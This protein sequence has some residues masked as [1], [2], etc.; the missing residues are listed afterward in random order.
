MAT[1]RQKALKMQKVL[2]QQE[3]DKIL[4]DPQRVK[5]ALI[6]A[7]KSMASKRYSKI[8]RKL[9]T[10]IIWGT[11]GHQDARAKQYDLVGLK[12]LWIK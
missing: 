8:S 2:R 3:L 12:Y 5:E 6:H 9:A 11:G 10:R 1:T 4:N 7:S